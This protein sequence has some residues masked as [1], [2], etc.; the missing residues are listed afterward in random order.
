[1]SFGIRAWVVVVV[2]GLITL[3]ACGSN[4]PP[5]GDTAT[6][7]NGNV[8]SGPCVKEG[9]TR[10]CHAIVLQ[11]KGF[12][13]C[14][15]G[16]QQCIGGAWSPCDGSGGTGGTLSTHAIPISN[17]NDLKVASF[18]SP[19]NTTPPCST[20]LC[21]PGCWGFNEVPPSPI[22]GSCKPFVGWGTCYEPLDWTL[23][24]A[25]LPA[26]N[27]Q[28]NGVL[29]TVCTISGS[30]DDPC[31]FGLKCSVSTGTGVCVPRAW[32]STNSANC[33][34]SS[35]GSGDDDDDDDS[36][37]PNPDFTLGMPCYDTTT[38]NFAFSICNHG[39]GNAPKTGTLNIAHGSGSANVNPT[40]GV[41]S[42]GL[43]GGCAIDLSA[44]TTTLRKGQCMTIEPVTDSR[45]G[46]QGSSTWATKDNSG[47]Q[48][49]FVNWS[50]AS[51]S[52]VGPGTPECDNSNNF[53]ATKDTALAA[54][55]ACVSC[56][57]GVGSPL[58]LPFTGPPP[59]PTNY[60][61]TYTMGACPTGYIGQW[62]S[63][64]YKAVIQTGGSI[65]FAVQ[66][67]PNATSAGP[68]PWNPTTGTPPG[69]LVA[70][71]PTDHPAQCTVTGPSPCG[72]NCPTGTSCPAACTCPVDLGTPLTT[73]P[74]TLRDAQQQQL[75]LNVAVT[76]A[77][78]SNCAAALSPGLLTIA[79][80][81][82]ACPGNKNIQGGACTGATDYT[83]C[84]QDFH[85]DAASSTCVYNLTPPWVDS[86]CTVNGVAGF[87]LTIEPACTDA[88]GNNAQVPICNR[89]GATIP[90]G[91]VIVITSTNYSSSCAKACAGPGT[92]D[93]SYTLTAPLAAG[94]C[95]DIPPS[96][97]CSLG[98][99]NTCLQVNPGNTV[100]DVNGHKECNTIANG[101]TWPVNGSGAGCN[102]NDTYVKNTPAGCQA[103]GNNLAGTAT[104][105]DSWQITY[106]CIA[107]E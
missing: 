30:G 3:V 15:N 88:A 74:L 53:T 36:T 47:D 64:G 97:G 19:S 25:L 41:P 1:M 11:H 38:T 16:T 35:S 94:S 57:G 7:N 80:G 72:S 83:S 95:I 105:L 44:A 101:G 43:A 59:K 89:G 70:N 13:D 92:A 104:E 46:T 58:P 48:W 4:L 55:E 103:C 52:M 9:E 90:A 31:E 100:V 24:Y 12:V 20:D 8:A 82:S 26:G 29:P 39:A 65:K 77:P 75:Q 14:F 28:A 60:S 98:S 69:V 27:Q 79:G 54:A 32:G 45:C 17:P 67:G 21:N 73:A 49:F 42:S 5:L 37:P 40:T 66:T 61:N 102:N 56:G 63:L 18:S 84:D 86:N 62:D 2:L 50:D 6:L 10:E 34:G 99:G 22:A 107:N 91:Q 68:G 106:S 33:G 81:I 78:G 85:C 76:P 71:A 87:D 93:C 96:A 23:Y 51:G